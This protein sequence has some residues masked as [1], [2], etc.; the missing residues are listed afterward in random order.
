MTILEA[1]VQLRNDL[2]L[3]TTNNLNARVPKTR[4]INNKELSSDVTLTAS[5]VGALDISGGTITGSLTVGGARIVKGAS[6][7]IIGTT[8]QAT[9]VSNQ[10]VLQGGAVFSGT[11]AKAGL[12]TRGICGVS[13]PDEN[14]ECNKE[15]LYINY[16]STNNY[17][18]GRQVVLQAGNVGTHYG[19][20][21]YQYAAARGDAV[22][23]WVESQGYRNI[24][25]SSTQPSGQKSGDFWYKVV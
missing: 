19:N 3:W 25:V 22:K 8:K 11:A 24:V 17:N 16:D 23:G 7:N 18:S 14:G 13:T 2:K 21:L 20:N 5:D 1:L 6:A 9:T 10:L 15:N 12:V 4:K